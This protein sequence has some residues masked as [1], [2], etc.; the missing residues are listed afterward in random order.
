MDRTSEA[1]EAESRYRGQCSLTY[2]S[3]TRPSLLDLRLFSLLAPVLLPSSSY[4]NL[5]TCPIT[6]LLH[7]SYPTL[8]RHSERVQ[9]LIWPIEVQPV[10]EASTNG[11]GNIVEKHFVNTPGWPTIAGR[12]DET[13]EGPPAAM[14]IR[15]ASGLGRVCGQMYY[16]TT[17]MLSTVGDQARH[18]SKEEVQTET[19]PKPVMTQAEKAEARRVFIGRWIWISSAVIGLIGTAFASGLLSVEVV[20]EDDG[21]EGEREVAQ[22]FSRKLNGQAEQE[23]LVDDNAEEVDDE[24]EYEIIVE[25][26]GDE[27]DEDN[28]DEAGPDPAFDEDD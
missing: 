18:E 20:E 28:E 7:S 19:R 25:G 11:R 21:E 23:K 10:L 17:S 24:E 12:Q 16:Y 2:S 6:L 26:K 13:D 15:L 4:P 9:K 14:T 5:A 3:R 22:F 1:R 27:D 8:V